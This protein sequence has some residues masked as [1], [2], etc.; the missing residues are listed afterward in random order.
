MNKCKRLLCLILALVTVV[1]LCMVGFTANAA[2]VE[3]AEVSAA[4][5]TS[6]DD[7]TWDNAT[8]YF[9]L[10][11]RFQNGNT[12]N[13]NSYNRGLNENGSKANYNNVAAFQ[14]GDFKGITQKI[15]DGYFDDLGVNAIWVA[16][17]FE[18]THGYVVGGDGKNSFAHY[19]YHGYYG[20]DFTE[21]DK[22]YG[23]EAEFKEMIDTAH[24]HGIRI[25]LDVVLNHPGYNSIYD[26]AEYNF[27]TLNSNW[28]QVY[29]NWGSINQSSYHGVI[30]YNDG[31]A[32]DWAR[33]WGRDWIRAGLAGYDNNGGGDLTGSVAYLPDFKTENQATLGIP[34]ILKTKWSREGTYN[35]KVAEI[36]QTFSKYNLGNKTVAN[37]LVAWY[38]KWVEEYGI[39]GFRCDTAKHVD[40]SCWK[41]LSDA[42]TKAL[43]N[44]R[45]ANPNAVG[46]DWDEDFWMTGEH[47][48]KGL[49]KDDYYTTGGFDSMINFSFSGNST[50]GGCDGMKK[51][52][53]LNQTYQTYANQINNDPNFNALSYISSHDTGLCRN[54]LYFQGSALLLLP[55]GVQ[56]YYGDETNRGLVDCTINDHRIRGFMNWNSMD[57]NIL[58]HWQKVGQFRNN[59]VAV[60]AGSHQSL[61]ATSGTAFVRLYNKNGVKDT[62]VCVIGA[63][64][65]SST[66]ITLNNAFADGTKVV[67]TY[68]G[69]KATVSGGKVTVNSGA[70]GT[71]LIEADATPVVTQPT[72]PVPTTAKPTEPA[73]KP[74]ETK[75]VETKPVETTP[76][77]TEPSEVITTAPQPTVKPTTPQPTVK[78]TTAPTPT[79]K[80]TVK[81]TETETTV[82][83]PAEY[84]VLG[85]TD[86]SEKVNIKDAT[87]IQKHIAKI[88]TLEDKAVFAGD[89]DG[90]EI[91]NIRDVTF[92]QKW[93]AKLEVEFTIGEEVVY[94]EGTN[95]PAT[96]P[97]NPVIFI[98]TTAP[99]TE[100]SEAPTEAPV[101][102]TDA[103]VVP[104]DAPVV[105]T[106]A[107][108]VPT[109]APV[110]PTDVPVD[111][112]DAPTDPV[113]TEPV[114][115]DPVND[116]VTIYFDNTYGWSSVY[117][118]AWNDAGGTNTP[119][120][121]DPMT[122]VSGNVYSAEVST[123][124]TGIIFND[125]SGSDYAKSDDTII[126][127]GQM[128]SN[129][130]WVDYDP[131]GGGGN[132]DPVPPTPDG[133]TIYVKDSAGWGTVYCHYWSS[134]SGSVWPGDQMTSLGNGVFSIS[135][136]SSYTGIVFNNGN[137]TQTGNLTLNFGQIYDNASDTWA[138]YSDNGGNGGDVVSG[139]YI[140]F[141]DNQGWGT[142]YCHTWNL[143]GGTTVWPGT[144]MENVGGNQYRVLVNS[145]HTNV[146]FNGGDGGPESGEFEL[147]VGNSYSN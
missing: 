140:Y 103:P 84:V 38:A 74:V 116:T 80:P 75:P 59:H 94:K 90:N 39:D 68:T 43:Q 81:P 44:W 15:K 58:A 4:T 127:A 137:G 16:G 102:P 108:E 76:A 69:E 106:D 124:F 7:F 60:G 28:K 31:Q 123:E 70:Q 82:V 135:I 100:A 49:G 133:N 111:P 110:V 42:C 72:T 24:E 2:E 93:L 64:K 26:M 21:L 12:S 41:R 56:I 120:P 17:W 92:I 119:W 97:S 6:A 79:V 142:V 86:F 88:E 9:L 61:N 52:G 115:T 40:K 131:N 125:G 117:W 129:G 91:L 33:W 36:D 19:A 62:V 113:Y 101:V 18:Q 30:K 45:T 32:S 107:P 83:V 14:G 96:K 54:D 53:N 139:D 126:S 23:T 55:G 145:T 98:P 122:H 128:Y 143:V 95:T 10:T 105:P 50:G 73:T 5:P 37:Y 65:N 34:E 22:N 130:S 20:L 29:Y 48:D 144:Q 141:T 114:Y 85:D 13:D 134:T 121:G 11:D 132:D 99:K 8:V 118:H 66:T 51:A 46:A 3:V 71:I 35:S 77:V 136:D 109:D 104:T 47:F 146:K 67:N 57:K 112:T 27:G 147:T 63:N 89:V 138:P 87:L 25:V 1:S 78:P